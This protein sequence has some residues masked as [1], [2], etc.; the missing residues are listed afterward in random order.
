MKRNNSEKWDTLIQRHLDGI[1]SDEE[2]KELSEEL[3]SSSETRKF[4]L[5]LQQI[6]A[7]LLSGEFDKPSTNDSEIRILE[8]ISNLE[9]SNHILGKRR[10]LFTLGSIAATIL[11][12]LGSWSL[13]LGRAE[14]IVEITSIQGD[15]QWT[16]DGGNVMEKLE[17]GQAL[18]GGTI[19]TKSINSAIELR[20][21][22]R[23]FG[24][25]DC[26]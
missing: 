3:E 22:I 25:N 18:T 24:V 11:V 10:F 7:I 15:I 20:F 21:D 26:R 19:E 23:W 1:A 14:M 5:K 6:H 2:V 17:E 16:G 8:L 13:W 12:L 9:R 4:Y